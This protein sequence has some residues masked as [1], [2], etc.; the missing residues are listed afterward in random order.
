MCNTTGANNTAVGHQALL[1]NTTGA[2]NVAV[3]SLSLDANTT[4]LNN[5]AVGCNAL[6]ANTTG[7]SNTAIGAGAGK[8]VTTG[9]ANTYVGFDAGGNATTGSG[10]IYIGD[11]SVASSAG[12]GYELV[13]GRV[14]GSGVTGKGGSTGFINPNSGGVYQ[15][16][17]SA[18]WSTTSDARIKKNIVDNHDG[19][20]VIKQI[21]VRNFEYRKPEEVDQELKPTDAVNKTGTQLGV[22]AQELQQ[23]IP[24]CVKQESTGVLTVDSDRMTWL[25]VNAVKELSAQVE[26]LKAKLESK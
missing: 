2:N 20:D 10:N 22:I 21:R 7:Q 9:T 13:I 8:G 18:N 23:V 17:N 3:G 6:G 24:E 14:D 15:G 11:N 26:D 4:G 1:G 12:V 16:N 19:L 5:A 25:L